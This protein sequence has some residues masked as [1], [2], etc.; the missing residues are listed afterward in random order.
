M[1]K[2]KP[3]DIE[4]LLQLQ[5]AVLLIKETATGAVALSEHLQTSVDAVLAQSRED[6]RH[7]LEKKEVRPRVNFKPLPKNNWAITLGSSVYYIGPRPN[8]DTIDEDEPRF[9]WYLNTDSATK[10]HVAVSLFQCL[11]G[12]I[13]DYCNPY[14]TT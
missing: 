8:F 11:I 14:E 2:P 10:Y 7:H 4:G 6:V 12:V 5:K 3:A 9:H 1:K 13:Q